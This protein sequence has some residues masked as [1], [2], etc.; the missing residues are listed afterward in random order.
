[1][2]YTRLLALGLVAAVSLGAGKPTPAPARGNWPGT[3]TTTP[4][5]G[6]RMGNPAAPVR[7]VEY[8]SYTCPHCAHFEIE[9]DGQLKMGYIVPGK[10]SVEVRHLVRDPVDLT[11]AMLTNCG[12]PARFFL[13]HAAFMRT[14]ATWIGPMTGASTAQLQRWTAGDPVVRRRNIASDFRLYAMAATRGI[15]RVTADRC[16]ADNALAQR[17][18]AMTQEAGELGVTSTPSFSLNGV[19]LTGTHDWHVL[20]PQIAARF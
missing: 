7:L 16:L 14:Q 1:M 9:A 10:V 2:H 4:G 20:A 19:L 13:N 17:L 5:G 11:V 12:P 3:I 18:A 6:H 15:D 8:V